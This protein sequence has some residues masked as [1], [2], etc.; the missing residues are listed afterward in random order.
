MTEQ[1]KFIER[2]LDKLSKSFDLNMLK[3]MIST[4]AEEEET[5]N[6]FNNHEFKIN[7]VER[8]LS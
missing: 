7:N 3:K 6:E 2:K 4:K 1:I 8:G 5:K